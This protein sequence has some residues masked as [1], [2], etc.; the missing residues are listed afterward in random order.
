LRRFDPSAFSWE[1]IEARPYKDDPGAARGMAWRG[2]S[3]HTLVRG[4]FEVRYFEIAPGGFS[5]LEKHAHEHAVFA[6]RG[7]GR[8]LV[9]DQVFELAPLDL[10]QTA[11]WLPHRWVN[12]GDEPFGFLCTVDGERDSPQ[13]LDDSEWQ[14]LLADPLTAPFA[15]L[16]LT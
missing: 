8:A 7:R 4:S 15:N 2:I 1:G 3:R 13:P 9:G 5:S 6:V 12:A 10:V 14:A 16:N 11:P